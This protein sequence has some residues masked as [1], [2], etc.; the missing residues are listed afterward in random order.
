MGEVRG[1]RHRRWHAVPPQLRRLRQS[2]P[3]PPTACHRKVAG[4]RETTR[5][6]SRSAVLRAPGATRPRSFSS[7][8]ILRTSIA[9]WL[10]DLRARTRGRRPLGRRPRGNSTAHQISARA[11]AASERWMSINN[12]KTFSKVAAGIPGTSLP[13]RYE[14]PRRFS[15][16]VCLQ[17]V[18]RVGMSVGITVG[19]GV[20]TII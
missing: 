10:A 14:I 7:A 2:R 15:Y 18:P 12:T 6:R 20:G 1:E 19:I 3:M 13:Y 9:P 17:N 8:V 5:T 16:R 4:Q 11:S